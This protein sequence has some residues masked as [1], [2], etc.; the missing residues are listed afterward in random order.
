MCQYTW[1][2][3]DARVVCRELGFSTAGNT[4]I[5]EQEVPCIAA[6]NSCNW[7]LTMVHA[8]LRFPIFII[9]AI[10]T[11]SSRYGYGGGSVV[12]DYV[13][14]T[15]TEARLA[16]CRTDGSVRSSCSHLNEAGVRCYIQTSKYSHSTVHKLIFLW[17]GFG[18]GQTY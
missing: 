16:N 9:G 8:C 13:Y 14:C 4:Y 12:L 1:D 17:K 5:L 15:G 2:A 11:Q 18:H 10:A 3:A 6:L 7:S